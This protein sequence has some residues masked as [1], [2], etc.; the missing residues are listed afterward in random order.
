MPFIGWLIAMLG[1]PV[2]ALG[3]LALIIVAIIRAMK[4]ERWRIPV[5]ADL[6][7]KW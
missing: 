7:D 3:G 5:V 4:G 2:L 6:A 1:S